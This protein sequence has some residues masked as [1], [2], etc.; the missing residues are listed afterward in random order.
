M[1][2]HETVRRDGKIPILIESRRGKRLGKKPEM[3]FFPFSFFLWNY[4]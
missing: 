1:K 2:P 3:A 4:N